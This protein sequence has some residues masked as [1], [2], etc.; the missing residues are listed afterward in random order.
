MAQARGHKSALIGGACLDAPRLWMAF[1]SDLSPPLRYGRVYSLDGRSPRRTCI[2][3]RLF[4]SVSHP[5]A[6]CTCA[7]LDKLTGTHAPHLLEAG[8]FALTEGL[9]FDNVVF[10]EYLAPENPVGTRVA[11]N[12]VDEGTR[13]PPDQHPIGLHGGIRGH[14]S[15]MRGFAP[16][17]AS[18][19][20]HSENFGLGLAE[21]G[22]LATDDGQQLRRTLRR[23]LPHP[24]RR[25]KH[26]L[27]REHGQA[28]WRVR[29]KRRG[30]KGS[31]PETRR[32]AISSQAM[33]PFLCSASMP[34]RP[35]RHPLQPYGRSTR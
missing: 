17:Y 32:G 27:G 25:H 35:Q 13:R 31:Y 34:C 9:A 2:G 26:R 3:P 16:F 28:C 22:G 7:E 30:L 29:D 33:A 19:S 11:Y 15:A 20:L 6:Q 12:K 8:G 14:G 10:T 5:W 23:V 18:V 4:D 24:H 1:T 21:L